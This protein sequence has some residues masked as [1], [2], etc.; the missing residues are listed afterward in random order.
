MST[1]TDSSKTTMEKI[2]VRVPEP[3]LAQIDEEWQQRGYT[4]KSAA[5]RDA[6]RDWVNPPQQLS[7]QT[8][9]ALETSRKQA[10]R[11]ETVSAE[12]ARERLG[13]DD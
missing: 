7:E 6:L 1:E 10:E 8:L 11:G 9:S 2:N 5:I 12:E 4:S 3:L 13:L